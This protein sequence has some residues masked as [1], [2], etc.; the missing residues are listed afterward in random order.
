MST[1]NQSLK[2]SGS[3]LNQVRAAFESAGATGRSAFRN[4][5][6]D[7][8]STNLKLKETTSFMDKLG[9]TFLNTIKWNIASSVMNNLTGSIQ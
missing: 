7:I 2:D 1:F 4:L 6:T 3:S 9:T 8:L 5:T